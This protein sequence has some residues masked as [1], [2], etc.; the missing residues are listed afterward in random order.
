MQHHMVKGQ[1]FKVMKHCGRYALRDVTI[2]RTYTVDKISRY[3]DGSVGVHFTD[4][5][6]C[7]L[8]IE[9]DWDLFILPAPVHEEKKPLWWRPAKT[10]GI[11]PHGTPMPVSAPG[12]GAARYNAMGGVGV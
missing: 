3:Y 12:A 6:G 5:D 8:V 4:N 7:R 10:A 1:K 2:G 11:L 9:E